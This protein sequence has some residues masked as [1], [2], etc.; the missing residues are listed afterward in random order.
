MWGGIAFF[1]SRSHLTRPRGFW[2][3]VAVR[4]FHL[5]QQVFG[6]PM[7]NPGFRQS[8][9]WTLGK[10]KWGGPQLMYI[11]PPNDKCQWAASVNPAYQISAGVPT[12]FKGQEHLNFTAWGAIPVQD[13]HKQKGWIHPFQDTW[14]T[15]DINTVYFSFLYFFLTHRAV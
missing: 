11:L 14:P 6:S 3:N 2:E 12:T 9:F 13:G 5:T 7:I 8:S 4:T 15:P 1:C 10:W